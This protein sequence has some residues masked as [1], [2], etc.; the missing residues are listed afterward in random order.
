[1]REQT[2]HLIATKFTFLRY[3]VILILRWFTVDFK[4]KNPYSKKPFR[5]NSYNHK[6]YWF[7]GKAREEGTTNSLKRLVKKGDVEGANLI[8]CLR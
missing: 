7:Y 3:F 6:G 4:I 2:K 8:T 5:L 1:V